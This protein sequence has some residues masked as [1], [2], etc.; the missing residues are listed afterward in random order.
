MAR[1]NP[2]GKR[3][4]RWVVAWLMD[5]IG[6]RSASR[7]LQ[8]RDG[9]R[10]GADV[11]GRDHRGRPWSVEVKFG[12]H[13][14]VTIYRFVEQARESCPEG[15]AVCV[16]RR[17]GRRPLVIMDERTFCALVNEEPGS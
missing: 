11:E 8:D 4:E 2:K 1:S 17:T 12:N 3:G 6:F 10:E 14:P 15:L 16:A 7:V 13:V 5:Q 9:E